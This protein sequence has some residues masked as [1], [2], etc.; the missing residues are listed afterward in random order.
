[1][2]TDAA[3][4]A[5]DVLDVPWDE[6]R[7]AR[8]HRRALEAFRTNREA[9]EDCVGELDEESGPD[10]ELDPRQN[11]DKIPMAGIVLS[12]RWAWVM[13]AVV[14][15]ATV[16]GLVLY[17]QAGS[18]PQLAAPSW[19][20][21]SALR[22]KDGSRSL[23]SEQAQVH[24]VEDTPALVRVRQTGGR[25]RY[26]IEPRRERRFQVAA[27]GVTITVLGTVFDV[28]VEDG[29]VA[30]SVG[31]GRVRVAHQRRTLELATG[32]HITI[33]SERDAAK[34]T[35]EAEDPSVGVQAAPPRPAE[36]PGSAKDKAPAASAAASAT[37]SASQHTA[38]ELLRQADSARASG[39]LGRAAQ[40]LRSLIAQ[41]PRDR[42]VTLVLFTL[43]RV[44]RQRGRHAV[45][46]RAFEQCGN[47]LG[48]DAIAESASSW[49]TAGQQ[50]RARRAAR[51]Y[52]TT[53]PNGV[54]A[55][56]MRQL[57]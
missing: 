57:Q 40:T 15:A 6:V 38:A 42:R 52:L 32:E 19:A 4:K 1:M 39:Q 47:A 31:R 28:A 41:Y 14:A 21:A 51:R 29:K 54:H 25:V 10:S 33:S 53:F 8:V 34:Q 48:G 16:C 5:R 22:F 7:A 9:P 18:D 11:D 27:H 30:V 46:A 56:R 45:A 36:Q 17:L 3:H 12:G 55:E 37:G 20:T 44:E 26:E 23:L 35:A 2:P 24:V 49:A 13:A 43:G 50:G